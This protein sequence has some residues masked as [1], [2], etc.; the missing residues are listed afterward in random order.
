MK[1]MSKEELVGLNLGAGNKIIDGAINHDR[2]KHREEI[3][4]AHDLNEIPWPWEDNTFDK[5]LSWA[6]FEHLDIDL[7][8]AVNECWRIMRPGGKLKIKLPWYLSEEAYNDPTHRYAVGRGVFDIFDRS[9]KR[10]RD[11]KFYHDKFGRNPGPWKIE[12]VI[13]S[14]TASCVVA[15]LIKEGEIDKK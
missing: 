8:T 15:E 4:V 5:I 6:V 11:Y 12:S 7:L 9:T 13:I 10:G 14:N 3:D 2:W 1:K